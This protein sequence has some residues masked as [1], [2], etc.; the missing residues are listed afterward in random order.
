LPRDYHAMQ[1]SVLPYQV[2]RPSVCLEVLWSIT[3]IIKLRSSFSVALN[4]INLIQGKHPQISRGIGVGYGK[5]CC[6]EHKSCTIS[7][8]S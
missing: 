8:R 5:S 4:M 3:G 2:V 1:S 6:S 7:E